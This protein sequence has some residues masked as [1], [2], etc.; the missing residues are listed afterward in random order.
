MGILDLTLTFSNDKEALLRLSLALDTDRSPEYQLGLDG[1]PRFNPG[2]FGIPAV[3]KGIWESED[4]FTLDIDEIGNIN[5][6][7]LTLTFEDDVVKGRISERTG[8]GSA[9][10]KGKLVK[11]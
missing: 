9:V 8:L 3:G 11:D 2:R 4:R 1:I 7:H 5:K 10:L 6:I